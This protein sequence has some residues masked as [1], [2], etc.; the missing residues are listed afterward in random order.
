MA[1]VTRLDRELVFPAL[2]NTWVKQ[3]KFLQAAKWKHLDEHNKQGQRYRAGQITDAE[4]L[5]YKQTWRRRRAVI[6]AAMLASRDNAPAAL[7]DHPGNSLGWNAVI[8]GEHD[9]KDALVQSDYDDVVWDD[10]IRDVG[11]SP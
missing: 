9:D 2:V 4:W 1:R 3:R 6:N 11:I 7:R 5:A 10:V 8:S